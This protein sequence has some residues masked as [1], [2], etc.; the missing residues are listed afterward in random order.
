MMPCSARPK[1]DWRGVYA[2]QIG[3]QVLRP[4][5]ARLFNL[6]LG[7]EK[8]AKEVFLGFESLKFNLHPV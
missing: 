8:T 5:R 2:L 4:F 6:S 3:V 7:T 1:N